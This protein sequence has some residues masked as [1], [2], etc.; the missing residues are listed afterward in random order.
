MPTVLQISDMHLLAEPGAQLLDTDTAQTL[1]A[2][3]KQALAQRCPDLLLATG[4]LAHDCGAPGYERFVRLVRRHYDGPVVALPG[5]H[6]LGDALRAVFS[7]ADVTAPAPHCASVAVG[8]WELLAIDSHRDG[9]PGGQLD[10]A[11][12]AALR[13]R[14]AAATGPL[15]LALHHPLVPVGAPWLDKDCP[16]NGASLLEW[17][18]KQPALRAVVYGHVHQQVERMVGDCAVL[19]TPSTCFQFAPHSAR[20]ALDAR[21]P[22]WRWLFLDEQGDRLRTQV[23]RLQ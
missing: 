13:A 22:G 10:E 8:H 5:N 17:L 11:L 7:A 19:G 3:L 1:E 2:V 6:D 16:A 14:V 23:D 12:L 9:E 21:P 15:L 20:F 18:A 4:D